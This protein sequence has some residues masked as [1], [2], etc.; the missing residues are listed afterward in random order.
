M[1]QKI[2]EVVEQYKPGVVFSSETRLDRDR[3]LAMR[4][5]LGFA[6]GKAVSSV[7]RSGGL[8]LFW[9]GMILC[10]SKVCQSLTLMYFYP[11]EI[12]R[13]NNGDFPVFI[14]NRGDA[15]G[16]LVPLEI[17]VCTVSGALAVR[18]GFQ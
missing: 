6:H 15:E 4:F 13:C 1:I 9:R 17:F 8:A 3:A 18:R 7:G 5:R 10:H 14:V 16:E 12:W 11:V 2:H